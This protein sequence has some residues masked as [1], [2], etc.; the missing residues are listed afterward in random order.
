MTLVYFIVSNRSKRVD[1]LGC[2][3][4]CVMGR[5]LQKDLGGRS[6]PENRM[7]AA[8]ASRVSISQEEGEV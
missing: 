1:A 3:G 4:S 5:K 7:L 2:C 6:D 8:W